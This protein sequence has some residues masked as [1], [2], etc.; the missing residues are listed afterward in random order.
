MPGLQP[1]AGLT[2]TARRLVALVLLCAPIAPARAQAPTSEPVFWSRT[3]L[4]IPYRW[5]GTATGA[6]EV[7]LYH[8]SDQ[9]R[10]WRVAGSAAPHVR[11][12]RF[13]APADGEHWFAVRTYDRAGV[14]TPPGPL[15]PEM[16]VVVDTAA[17][18]IDR[19]DA[20]LNAG[21]LTV[22]LELSDTTGFAAQPLTL[23]A[24]P[25]GQPGWTPVP[26]TSA[27]PSADNRSARVVAQW[28][29]PAGVTR[30]D[31]RATVEDRAGNRV[32]RS[33]TAEAAQ[34]LAA[35]APRTPAAPAAFG[36]A[37]PSTT[38]TPPAP[39]ATGAPSLDPFADAERRQP[40]AAK[41][42]AAPP[43]ASA[44]TPG[45]NS[46]GINSM[47]K[48]TPWPSESAA[49]RPLVAGGLTGSVDRSQPAFSSTP[50][51]SASFGRSPADPFADRESAAS[52]PDAAP[53]SRMVN[54][55]EFD[56]DYELNRTGR[57]GVAKVELWGTD[58]GGRSWRRFAIDSDRESPIHVTT[59]GEGTYGFRLVVESIGGLEATTPRPGDAPEAVVGVDLT[60]PQVLLGDVRQGVGYFA[61]QLVIEWRANDEHL[62]ER[63][64]DL[65]YSNRETGPWIPIATN[66]P[67]N[68][69]HSWR[70]Q[71][72]LPRQLFL[73]AEAR[74]EA[75][76]VAAMTT[77]Q[78]IE[79]DVAVASG[80]LKGV[81]PSGN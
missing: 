68:G 27:Q 17:P 43:F 60:K 48:S 46:S 54:S 37:W 2:R 8:S 6:A 11:S 65:F 45:F 3:E 70:L 12:F 58:D 21:L 19:L 23:Y 16:R 1:P 18:T 47:A 55:T 62:T 20:Q 50:F 76:N 52:S 35:L 24:Q 33:A 74:D 81:R 13:Q 14:A 25:T 34:G 38:A 79:V 39:L 67:N 75:G 32:E 57:W 49:S 4:M 44:A 31:V 64:I 28:R 29:P 56:F 40:A 51:S 22:E 66:L 36:T 7:V 10:A 61:D 59:P 15:G 72:H 71:R 69:R 77:P 63:P 30:I 42:F 73:R 41:P 78:A 80:S 53:P 26:V 9:G 5:A